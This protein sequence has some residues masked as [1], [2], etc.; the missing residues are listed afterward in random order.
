[1][2]NVSKGEFEEYRLKLLELAGV[3][4]ASRVA[5][6]I[7]HLEHLIAEMVASYS[8][9]KQVEEQLS[10][11]ARKYRTLLKTAEDRKNQIEKDMKWALH[12]ADTARTNM[13]KKESEVKDM[14]KKLGETKGA[15]DVATKKK[16]SLDGP[17]SG[18]GVEIEATRA[19]IAQ[20]EKENESLQERVA[21]VQS[22]LSEW[23][24]MRSQ[25][26]LLHEKS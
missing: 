22:R 13:Q 3:K 20:L 21:E 12:K 6:A 4:V 16:N 24:S 18:V 9:A 25:A 23:H 26:A 2:V 19:E 11:E 17:V 1:M 10:A 5:P 8:S 7:S 15:L 14:R